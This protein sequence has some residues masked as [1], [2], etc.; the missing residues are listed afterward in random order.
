[1]SENWKEI[2]TQRFP[3]ATAKTGQW[4]IITNSDFPDA[5]GY[6]ETEA[7]AWQDAAYAVILEKR[8]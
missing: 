2:V 3:N 7:L 8:K 5:I 4:K 6:G 1:M